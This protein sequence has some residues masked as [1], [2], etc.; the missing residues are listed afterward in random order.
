MT[1]ID[2]LV[3]EANPYPD[4][5]EP[6][7]A[8]VLLDRRREQMQTQVDVEHV[9]ERRSRG[10]WVG[11]AA[12]IVV[13]VG[14]LIVLQTR[15]DSEVASTTPVETAVAFAEA[16]AAGDAELAAGYLTPETLDSAFDGLA[17]L[18]R[19][20]RWRE[21]VGFRFL[22][23][24]CVEVADTD[25]GTQIGCPYAYHALLSDAMGLGPYEGS[26]IRLTVQ[27]GVIT[28]FHDSL[29][30]SGNGFSTQ[31]W[32]PFSDWIVAEYPDDVATLYT[33]ALMDQKRLTDESIALWERRTMEYVEQTN[34][35][36]PPELAGSWRGEMA[37][38]IVVGLS[39]GGSRYSAEVLGAGQGA[40]SISGEVV[41]EGDTIT[42]PPALDCPGP[43]SYSWSVDGDQ[44]T[45]R[46]VAD[47]C[48]GMTSWDGTVFTKIQG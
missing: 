39:L 45:L 4:L 3:R 30:F 9:E 35:G 5:V 43:R 40:P 15:D 16:F 11:I 22:L 34:G 28:L 37:N 25:A 10:L 38:G 13:V 18:D 2:R 32:E 41:V 8:P 23:D 44:L 46:L 19:E 7:G 1:Q 21:A 31:V 27:D 14:G 24:E 47:G 26:A 29:E 36:V 6:I 42:F 20:L 12:G 48:P 33:T 17:G